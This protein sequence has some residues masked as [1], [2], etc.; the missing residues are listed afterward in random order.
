VSYQ[1][2]DSAPSNEYEPCPCPLMLPGAIARYRGTSRRSQH[3]L[4]DRLVAL[5]GFISI[6][7]ANAAAVMDHP[8]AVIGEEEPRNPHRGSAAASAEPVSWWRRAGYRGTAGPARCLLLALDQSLIS[9]KC[10][11]LT[12]CCDLTTAA[13]R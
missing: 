11:A 12:R 6:A 13:A 10:R 1:G 8:S 2:S 9:T 3:P 7:P 4:S 5:E